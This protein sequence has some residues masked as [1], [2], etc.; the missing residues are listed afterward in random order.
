MI[1]VQYSRTCL[2]RRSSVSSLQSSIMDGAYCMYSRGWVTLRSSVI[3]F[4]YIC[5]V[6]GSNASRYGTVQAGYGTYVW[7]RTAVHIVWQT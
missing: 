1:P 2:F 4:V 6:V 5:V 7:Y 3:Y